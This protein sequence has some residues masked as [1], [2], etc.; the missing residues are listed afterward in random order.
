M[1]VYTQKLKLTFS[2]SN[3]TKETEIA[4]SGTDS[5]RWERTVPNESDP[6]ELDVPEVTQANIVSLYILSTQNVT[7]RTNS[8]TP[9]EGVDEIPLKANRA[10]WWDEEDYNDC[11]IAG[12]LTDN[13]FVTNESG[14]E[15]VLTFEA[16]LRE[17]EAE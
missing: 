10:Y 5:V 14:A 13:V 7:F 1:A 9:G 6:L 11:L 2:S 8:N 4:P 3:R 15:A 12:N 16:I 17:P